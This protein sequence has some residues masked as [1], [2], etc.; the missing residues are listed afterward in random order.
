MAAAAAMHESVEAL[1]V[2][3]YPLYSSWR[4]KYE[5]LGGRIGPDQFSPDGA[6][7]A[8]LWAK[9]NSS[10]EEETGAYERYSILV[11]RLLAG[12][13]WYTAYA[14][15]L[16]ADL[17]ETLRRA[18]DRRTP[19]RTVFAHDDAISRFEPDVTALTGVEPTWINGGPWVTIEHPD[20]VAEAVR[21]FVRELS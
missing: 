15:L 6:E 7:L 16:Q 11:D 1:M 19:V 8:D 9:L 13:I 20:R 21:S 18:V 17:D 2:F 4:E 3:G 14:A 5:R 12:P 10:I